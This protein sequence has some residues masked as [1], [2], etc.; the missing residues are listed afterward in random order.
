M[1]VLLCLRVVVVTT[2]SKQNQDKVPILN[3]SEA[4]LA[5]SDKVFKPNHSDGA[6]KDNVFTLTGVQGLL[7][8]EEEPPAIESLSDL[9]ED[10]S[11]DKDNDLSLDEIDEKVEEEKTSDDDTNTE[12]SIEEM[13]DDGLVWES[14]TEIDEGGVAEEAEIQTLTVPEDQPENNNE[15]AE[16]ESQIEKINILDNLVSEMVL[17]FEKVED[18]LTE[19]ITRKILELTS[20][21]IGEKIDGMPEVIKNKID[22]LCSEVKSNNENI[23]VFLSEADYEIVTEKLNLARE[24]VSF[25]IDTELSRG[26]VKVRTENLEIEDNLSSRLESNNSIEP[27]EN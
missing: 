27:S 22:K 7:V 16:V 9:D 24:S 11:S 3:I 23:K 5:R 18:K 19:V 21:A 20:Q 4:L 13:E 14:G 1:L 6:K 25:A 26:D 10:L 12:K 15:G 2:M 8:N 17:G